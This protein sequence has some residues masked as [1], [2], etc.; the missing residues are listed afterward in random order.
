MFTD[1]CDTVPYCYA[2]ETAADVKRI[3][4]DACD[5]VRYRYARESAVT[6]KCMFAYICNSLRNY[7]GNNTCLFPW[8]SFP[9]SIIVHPPRTADFEQTIAVES[10]CNIVS[11]LAAVNYSC[12]GGFY[13][14]RSGQITDFF[15]IERNCGT[16][17][18]T[19]RECNREHPF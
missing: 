3:T 10:V 19:N 7:N 16:D 13:G 15:R 11:A 5:G 14:K 1:A 6:G 4:T 17:C 12:C 18:H 2:R 8:R 9:R